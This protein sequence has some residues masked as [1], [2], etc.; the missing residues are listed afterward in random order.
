VFALAAGVPSVALS[1]DPKVDAALGEA[2]A[3]QPALPPADLSAGPLA[4]ALARA[5][6][7][8]AEA[9]TA[10]SGAARALAARAGETARL[11]LPLATERREDRPA[12]PRRRLLRRLRGLT[13]RAPALGSGPLAALDAR[14]AA[15][16]GAVVFPPTIGWNVH[17]VQRPHHLARAF[18][19][20][21]YLAVFD[22]SN[23]N[24]DVENVREVE[25]GV[26][27]YRGEHAALGALRRTALWTFPYNFHLREH[28]RPTT[29]VVYDWID[30]LDVFPHDRA[31]LERNHR[32]G[33]EEADVVASVARTLHDVA[34]RIRPDAVYLPNA[35]DYDRF[36]SPDTGAAPSD[37]ALEAVLAAGRP[38]AGYYGALARWFDYGLLDE[39]AGLRPDWS[40]LLI[41][42][43][44]DGSL[45]GQPL[46][47]RPN[48][49]WL[50]VRPYEA[51]PQY[52]RRFDV[53]T[54]PFRIDDITRSTSPLKLFE[55][56]AAGKPV[57]T[58]PMPEC[59][60]FAEVRV[61]AGAGAF[62]R[63][64]DAAREEAEDAGGRVSRRAVARANTWDAR[65]ARVR[66]ALERLVG[67]Y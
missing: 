54:I 58:T 57:V 48:V 64:L 39:L 23:S 40:F 9:R 24:D 27:L 53:A 62:A 5:L 17:L 61:A 37:E 41:G 18:A 26:F 52:L 30:D 28:H 21:G 66:P 11:V 38:I 60:A 56:F 49:A 22:S 29:A 45:A 13:F 14:I 19:R 47:R 12:P 15:A 67:L 63:A 31:L 43:D 6:A 8:P 42:P 2:G 55:Y 10:F 35:V 25:P 65:V 51:L 3:P 50:G 46:L 36:A 34:C 33:L 59:V 1:Y 20:A 32:G 7:E 44:L 16:R 4:E